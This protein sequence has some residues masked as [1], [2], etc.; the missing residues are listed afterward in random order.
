MRSSVIRAV[1]FGLVLGFLGAVWAIALH[2]HGLSYSDEVW[3][4]NIFTGTVAGQSEM[5]RRAAFALLHGVDAVP[6][7]GCV[8]APGRRVPLD[9]IARASE[10][11]DGT[12]LAPTAAVA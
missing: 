5:V 6:C 10:C 2:S 7:P 3:L 9:L 8:K 1:M 4:E 12:H 11:V